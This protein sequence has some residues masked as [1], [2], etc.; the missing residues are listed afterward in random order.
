MKKFLLILL[1]EIE[2]ESI[3]LHI[4]HNADFVAN[5]GYNFVVRPC[6]G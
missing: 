6:Q 5:A 1:N 3:G 2:A 4:Y